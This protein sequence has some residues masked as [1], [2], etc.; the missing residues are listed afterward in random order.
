ML[1]RAYVLV[2]VSSR[3]CNI[4]LNDFRPDNTQLLQPSVLA[5]RSAFGFLS[6]KLKA[7]APM[8]KVQIKYSRAESATITHWCCY[9]EAYKLNYLQI[10][11]CDKTRSR[12]FAVFS[13][14]FDGM[15]A[16]SARNQGFS[17]HAQDLFT[18]PEWFIRVSLP[19]RSRQFHAYVY[20]FHIF[21][22]ED[23]QL[24]VQCS[25]PKN[26]YGNARI[27]KL[28]SSPEKLHIAH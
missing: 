18:N 27:Q 21:V 28:E 8:N 25:S 15:S 14:C 12:N 6:V 3:R 20:H 23:W 11:S 24:Q 10:F 22:N 1:F 9:Y 7:T 5:K 26:V 13:G 4:C 17:Q 2:Q 16:L 19:W